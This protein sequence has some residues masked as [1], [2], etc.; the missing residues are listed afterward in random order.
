MF[1]KRPDATLVRDASSVRRFMPFISPR[2]NESLVYFSQELDVTDAL[3]FVSER[4]AERPDDAPVTLFH[5]IL[6][7][8]ARV[9]E[10]RPR[11]NRFVAGGRL[12]QR[13]G[14][15]LTFSAKKRFDDDGEL[16]TVKRKVDPSAPLDAWVDHLLGGIREGK[17]DTKSTSDREVDLLLRLPSPVVRLLMG[18]VHAIDAF[19]LLPLGMIRPDPMYA[20]AFI[21]N[22]GSVGLEAGYHHL[23]E[24]GNCPVFCV[25][26]RI[27]EG[28]DERKR[29]E[30]K[31]SYD[32]RT[33]DGLY[34]AT[35][36]ER[37][38]ELVENPA[39]LG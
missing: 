23:W 24:H 30:L 37:L 1:G 9:L 31:W 35:S 18:A 32:E 17:S 28:A 7:A 36:L 33:E 20:S 21:A 2:R 25:I 5:L 15:W 19:G 13:D 14:I 3:A 39:K 38:R 12:W 26:G 11:L 29:V 22:L 4:N 34:C 6:R 16:T 8:L 10:E 27:R